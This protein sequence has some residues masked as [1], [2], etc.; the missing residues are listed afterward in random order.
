MTLT[1]DA[2]EAVR[3]NEVGQARDLLNGRTGRHQ[4]RYG[5]LDELAPQS[6]RAWGERTGARIR[7]KRILSGRP[8]EVV[9]DIRAEARRQVLPEHPLG[10]RAAVRQIEPR[11][12]IG[13][14]PVDET[15]PQ[16][17]NIPLQH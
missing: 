9:I 16:G 5:G 6:H 11:E 15:V 17:C 7:G 1:Y 14:A 2:L 10:S 8:G 3:R 4:C 12:I 13:D